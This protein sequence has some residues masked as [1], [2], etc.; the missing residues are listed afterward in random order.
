MN[1]VE[2]EQMQHKSEKK[3]GWSVTH[4]RFLSEES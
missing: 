1:M 2:C 3:L 4:M